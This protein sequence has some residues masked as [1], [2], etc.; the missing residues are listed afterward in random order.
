MKMTF[1]LRILTWWHGYTVGTGLFTWRKGDHVGT[2]DDGNKYYREKGGPKRW[3]LYN[4]EI[5]A[6]RVPPEW[7]AWL[8]YIVA[9]P[10]T[11]APPA[12]QQWERE[13]VANL[14]GTAGAYF[15]DGSLNEGGRRRG[16]SG[17]YEAWRP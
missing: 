17:D 4:G 12:T 3:V 1:F 5:E 10:P 8:H 13:H 14:T 15:P 7:H 11:E 6:S 16:T 2:D 9:Q